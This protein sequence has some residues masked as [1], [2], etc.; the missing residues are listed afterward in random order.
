MSL[1]LQKNAKGDKKGCLS[2]VWI[3][4]EKEGIGSRWC[5]WTRWWRESRSPPSYFVS[6]FCPEEQDIKLEGIKHT[7]LPTIRHWC[8]NGNRRC[9]LHWGNGSRD[10]WDPAGK[11]QERSVWSMVL[12]EGTTA[13]A[14]WGCAVFTFF[15]I[16]QTSSDVSLELPR[17][18]SANKVW[19]RNSEFFFSKH[20]ADPQNTHLQ[21]G[22][23]P[24]PTLWE[25]CSK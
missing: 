25:F 17:F 10:Y 6:A 20:H 18:S 12:S 7:W 11:A 22:L 3:R 14:E 16:N 24:R 23:S 9:C 2:Y 13:D 4:K 21:N 19:T 1:G 15:K 5:N 8:W